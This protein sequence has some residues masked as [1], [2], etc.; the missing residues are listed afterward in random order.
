MTPEGK[1]KKKIK[2]LLDSYSGRIYYYMPVPSGYGRR[3]VDYLGCAKGIFF[4]IEA[5]KPG[6][7]PTALQEGTLED[8]RRTGGMVFV[9][10][11]DEGVAALKRWLDAVMVMVE[12]RVNIERRDADHLC[13]H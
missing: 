8:I 6:G 9:V 1:V 7:K 4:A 3:T 11:G 13:E 10:D 12:W 2:L 5:K